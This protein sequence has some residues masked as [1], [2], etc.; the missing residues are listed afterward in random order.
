M[1]AISK[2]ATIAAAG[3]GGSEYWVAAIGGASSETSSSI[4]FDPDGNIVV[5]GS[6]NTNVL[7]L[8][9]D[10]YG[11]L[12]WQ[13]EIDSNPSKAE[14]VFDMATDS[15]GDIYIGCNSYAF[16]TYGGECLLKL[17]SS[18]NVQWLKGYTNAYGGQLKFI[19]VDG[20]DRIH[21]IGYGSTLSNRDYFIFNTSGGEIYKRRFYQN[22]TGAID[23]PN[24]AC[25][26]ASG[27]NVAITGRGNYDGVGFD[28]YFFEFG[29]TGL[30]T[31]NKRWYGSTT[32]KSEIAYGIA[33][34]SS[35]TYYY[36]SVYSADAL[37]D[38][39]FKFAK[40][41]PATS[42]LK[43]ELSHRFNE[44]VSDNSGYMYGL[45]Y[46][47]SYSYIVK[48]DASF[49]IIWQRYVNMGVTKIR[50]DANDNILIVGHMAAGFG[51]N[52][53]VFAKLPG[54]GSGTGT[55]G[56]F[57]SYA[58]TT[59]VS[60]GTT[61]PSYPY[62]FYYNTYSQASITASQSTKATTETDPSLSYTT[63]A[64]S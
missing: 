27:N 35:E 45:F 19:F 1:S 28:G 33:L 6:V 64:V 34:D 23:N 56:G 13:T 5:S 39:L 63:E 51:S 38:V 42:V 26:S 36:V 2:F 53:I 62:E 48:F 17:N 31:R 7:A 9:T 43:R 18:G 11:Q 4:N 10:P 8:K 21:A 57:F 50:I 41:S 30:I 59:A 52:D 46:G 44:I 29:S 49:N 3:S 22:T 60:I 24:A 15:S 54:D 12:L 40:A 32:S 14:Y 58:T 20:S 55:Y 25:I 37:G 16:G 61:T 47:G